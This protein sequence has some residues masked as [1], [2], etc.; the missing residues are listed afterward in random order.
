MPKADPVLAKM[1]AI[2][3]A[4]PDT[5]E[6]LTWGEPHF[7]VGE[8]IFAG[9]GRHRG[10]P[11]IGFKL[12]KPHADAAV[13]DPRFERAPYVGKHGWVSMDATAI[14]DWKQVAAMIHE[15]YGLIATCVRKKPAA[16]P[17]GS[18]PRASK[19]AVRKR[20]PARVSGRRRA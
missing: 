10:K 20:A 7:R 14:D 13:N 18:R 15:S 19:K 12:T 3:L 4:L 17:G 6:T 11:K 16:R 2:C 9:C 8:K 5:K 1:R